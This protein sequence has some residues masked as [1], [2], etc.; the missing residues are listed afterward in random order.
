[1]EATKDAKRPSPHAQPPRKSTAFAALTGAV[2]IGAGGGAATYAAFRSSDSHTVVRQ[3][4]VA[5]SE[6]TAAQSSL[7][8]AQVY[9]RAYKGV[10]EITVTSAGQPDQLGGSQSQ[11]ALGSG[12]VY[13]DN[14]HIVTNEHVVDGA[15]SI[16][17]RLW[18]GAKYK[19]TLVGSDSST[20]L[21]VL[22]LDAPTSVLH[23][24]TLGDSSA[25]GRGP[26]RRRDRQPVRSRGDRDD[27]HRQRPQPPIDSTNGFTIPGS[28]QTDAAINHG[29]SGGPLLDIHGHVI[30]VTRRSRATR[31]ATT[32][33][34]SRSP[35]TPSPLHRRPAGRRRPG[36]S[37][38]ISA[39]AVGDERRRARRA[40][41]QRDAG[42]AGRAPRRRP[43][44]GRQRQ[45]GHRHGAGRRLRSTPA[46]RATRSR[47][48]TRA[49]GRATPPRS[50]SRRGRRNGQRARA[51]SGI[52]TK[53]AAATSTIV[54]PGGRSP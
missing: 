50:R 14:G 53:N 28:I 52:A 32:A 3:V 39:S 46:S 45:V 43:D 9:Q 23:P 33:S 11:Q 4:T 8:V 7:S 47:S 26:G 22:K 25:V 10:V 15:P 12:F 17:V 16:S 29:N 1:M 36:R 48:A 51:P 5:S 38:R 54:P 19:A 21:A 49:T 24:L 18:N 44:Q 2:P 42:S 40:G 31:T 41:A 20:D 27:R 30:G 13:D 34:V 35:R 6:P 37:T